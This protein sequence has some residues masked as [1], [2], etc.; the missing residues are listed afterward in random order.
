MPIY[1]ALSKLKNTF[2]QFL[3]QRKIAMHQMIYGIIFIHRRCTLLLVAVRK[4]V[5]RDVIAASLALYA[6]NF[7]SAL[8]KNVVTYFNQ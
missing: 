2:F 6:H 5:L 3:I 1:L 8:E 7:A 4:N